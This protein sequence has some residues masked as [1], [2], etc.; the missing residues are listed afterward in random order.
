MAPALPIIGNGDF[1]RSALYGQ[2]SGG[3]CPPVDWTLTMPAN[4]VC[5]KLLYT[6]QPLR[7]ADRPDSWSSVKAWGQEVDAA[8]VN[9]YALSVPASSSAFN[10]WRAIVSVRRHPLT[11]GGIPAQT[12]ALLALNLAG[13]RASGGASMNLGSI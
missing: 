9:R 5:I 6:K 1:G 11:L 8:F 2:L 12:E 3:R 4:G 13:I 7:C 10:R